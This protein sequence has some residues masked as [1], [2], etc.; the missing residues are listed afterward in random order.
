[1]PYIVRR[2]RVGI[3]PF[4]PVADYGVLLRHNTSM[5]GDE[6]ISL[7]EDVDRMMEGQNDICCITGSSITQVSSSPCLETLRKKGRKVLYM[8]P[9]ATAAAAARGHH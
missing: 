8:L 6:Q 1:M 7:R 4:G 9:S 5:S 2:L 3:G